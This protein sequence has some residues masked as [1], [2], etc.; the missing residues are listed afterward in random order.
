MVAE[1]VVVAVVV[2]GL[3][4]VV[5]VV[6]VVVVDVF[7]AAVVVEDVVVVAVVE[8]VV[9]EVVVVEVVLG[10]SEKT[11][12]RQRFGKNAMYEKWKVSKT[13]KRLD[14]THAYTLRQSSTNFTALRAIIETTANHLLQH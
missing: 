10:G 3:G 7:V 9:L 4:V 1:L 14:I 13:A 2:G 12:R 11:E 8:V 5:V 6:E